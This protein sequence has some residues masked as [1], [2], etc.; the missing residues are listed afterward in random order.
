MFSLHQVRD[1]ILP[2]PE[3][4]TDRNMPRE[5]IYDNVCYDVNNQNLHGYYPARNNMN[6]VSGRTGS[7][8][9]WSLFTR[10]LIQME[11]DWI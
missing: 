4:I 8:Q 2:G 5:N 11:L 7:Y 9:P 1:H 3:K 10:S 6:T